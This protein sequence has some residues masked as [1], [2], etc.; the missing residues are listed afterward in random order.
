MNATRRWG[1]N[2]VELCFH[3]VA[4]LLLSSLPLAKSNKK[5]S[6]PLPRNAI[7][8]RVRVRMREEEE[9]G[10]GTL[11][12]AHP[13]NMAKGSFTLGGVSFIVWNDGWAAERGTC[14]EDWLKDWSR[15]LLLLLLA[16][17][18]CQSIR[19]QRRIPSSF[20]LFKKHSQFQNKSLIASKTVGKTTKILCTFHPDR[21]P[22]LP[23]T[24]TPNSVK[25]LFYP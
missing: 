11:F 25:I 20:S 4:H 19:G 6:L 15:S 9:E 17:L 1:S 2:R 12:G 16:S 22:Q 7:E 5:T 23:L 13:T 3:S 8:R 24:S 21:L 10:E 18:C 14:R